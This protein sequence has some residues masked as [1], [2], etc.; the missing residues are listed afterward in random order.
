MVIL[1]KSFQLS[2]ISKKIQ[3]EMLKRLMAM[4]HR[5]GYYSSCYL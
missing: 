3:F 2:A 4:A 5:G 1:L